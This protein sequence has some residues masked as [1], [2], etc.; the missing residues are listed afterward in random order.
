MNMKWSIVFAVLISVVFAQ[1][2][3]E[4]AESRSSSLTSDWLSKK[5]ASNTFNIKVGVS[6]ANTDDSPAE[7]DRFLL[8]HQKRAGSDVVTGTNPPPQV[9]HLDKRDSETSTSDGPTGTDPEPT[10]PHSDVVTGADP[11]PQVAHLDKRDSE[12]S[13]SDGPTGTD[14]EPTEPHVASDLSDLETP[15]PA[16][17]EKSVGSVVKSVE[18]KWVKIVE[19]VV[20]IAVGLPLLIIIGLSCIFCCKV[21]RD[22]RAR[23]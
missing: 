14:P 4:L 19:I 16:T 17:E 7:V 11:E 21:C 3:I 23:Y 8:I 13:S 6:E 10:E 15:K 2:M 12:T 18:K 20:P 9:A 22:R 1:G 5:L